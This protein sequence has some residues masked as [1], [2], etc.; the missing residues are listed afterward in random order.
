M[1]IF[2]E[3]YMYVFLLDLKT[4]QIL[5]VTESTKEAGNYAAIQEN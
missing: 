4:F 5:I 1:L 2:I 3:L